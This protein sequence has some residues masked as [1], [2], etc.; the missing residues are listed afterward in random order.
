MRILSR[1]L[2]LAGLAVASAAASADVVVIVSA[3][4]AASSMTADEI[5]G[6]YL[7]K[8]NALKPVD[9]AGAVRGE[10][11]TKVAGKDEAQVK[12][13]W[14][15]LVFTG[16]ATPPRELASSGDVVKAVGADPNAIG[17]VE[18]SALDASVKVVFEVK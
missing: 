15:K 16:K 12:A 8:S 9:N 3:K 14:S 17:Y 11:Y 18:K 10:F 5:A 13:I 2:V 7:G 4:N 1:A 6:I